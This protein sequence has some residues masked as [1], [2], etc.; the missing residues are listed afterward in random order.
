[1]SRQ[2]IE[3][4]NIGAILKAHVKKYRV[5]QS[6]WA[7]QEGLNVNTINDYL[8]RKD[9]RISTLL[10]ISQALNYNFFKQI[11]DLLPT[12]MPP[13]IENPLQARVTELEKQNSELELQLKTL[14]EAIGLM[15]GR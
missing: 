15:G 13:I 9:M 10:D 1:M 8:K 2:K 11:A 5:R 3:A 6:G 7:R 12:D 14:K 4:P